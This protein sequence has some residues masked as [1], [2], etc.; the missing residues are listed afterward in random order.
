MIVRYENKF[1]EY[2]DIAALSETEKISDN[3]LMKRDAAAKR[4]LSFK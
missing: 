1:K 3:L 4:G 2:T